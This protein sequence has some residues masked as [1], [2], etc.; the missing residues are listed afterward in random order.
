MTPLIFL[1]MDGV[2]VNFTE[3][4]DRVHGRKLDWTKWSGG[5]ENPNDF[6]GPINECP[7]FW[8]NLE[9]YPWATDLILGIHAL[10]GYEGLFIATSPAAEPC[11]TDKILWIAKRSHQL[12]GRTIITRH[13]HLLAGP[14]RILIDDSDNNLHKW[15]E[16]GGL[17]IPFHQPWNKAGRRGVS[18][19]LSS[20]E[21]I[22][23]V[24]TAI[25]LLIT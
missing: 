12:A 23:Y 18:E 4:A 11:S 25:K 21:R 2:L 1:D 14:G 9:P 3:G 13:K 20:E 7:D 5:I 22:N 16:H 19:R 17:A 15:V 10:V 24:I 6:W 8:K